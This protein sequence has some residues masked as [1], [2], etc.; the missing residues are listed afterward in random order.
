MSHDQAVAGKA[1]HSLMT[2]IEKLGIN[3]TPEFTT[4]KKDV[5]FGYQLNDKGVK[6]AVVLNLEDAEKL[7]QEGKFEGT[8]VT[9]AIT[10]PVNFAA[11][12]QYALNKYTTK[13]EDGKEVVRDIN[14]VLSDVINLCRPG[15]QVKSTNRRNQRLLELDKDGN[16]TFSDKD[17]TDGV[18]DLTS[19]ITSPS[20]RIVLTEE[21]KTWKSL[22]NLTKDV[23]ENMWRVYL[24][25][26]GKEFYVPQD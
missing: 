7:S 21:Q 23:R 26:L 2:E 15:M 16:L 6:E 3:P 14:E 12:V 8:P 4:I 10:L 13:G 5:A 25:S 24:T 22:S 20:R 1:Q 17:L 19:E 9:T 18:L 11:F